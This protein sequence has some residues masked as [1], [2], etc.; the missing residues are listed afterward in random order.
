MTET[1]L[2]RPRGAD[3]DRPRDDRQPYRPARPE[4]GPGRALRQVAGVNETILD[5][6]PEERPRYTRLGAIVLN[7]GVMAMLSMA[8]LLSKV[9]VPFVAVVPI[10]VMWGYLILSFDGW[11]VASTHG[12][13]GLAKLRTY[14]PRMAISILMGVVIAEP[15]LLWVFGPAIETEVRDQREAVVATYEARLKE[16][17]PTS[18]AAPAAAGCGPFLLNVPESPESTRQELRNA[19]LERTTLEGRIGQIDKEIARREQL[20]RLECNGTKVDGTTGRPGVG[21]N[22]R[23]N[24]AEADRYQASSNVDKLRDDLS[25]LDRR[26]DALTAREGAASGTY[27]G[28]V[29]TE[30]SKRVAD[31]RDNQDMIGIL[32]EIK[33]LDS[34]AHKS[35]FVL[36]ASWLLRLLLV[37]ID[38]LPV[39]TKLMSRTTTYDVL[40]GRQLDVSGRLH[41]KYTTEREQRDGGRID[42]SIL[43]NEH[44]VRAQMEQIDE[45]DRDAR[46]QREAVL[47]D[48]IERLAARLRDD[49]R[50]GLG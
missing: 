33:A 11:L 20:A 44:R 5:W 3:D 37:A 9:D 7:T 42:V 32:D 46:A 35:G 39:L 17:N 30:I 29:N 28:A 24:R 18:G 45:A 16:C 2:L 34:L 43:E 10:A 13:L 25:A 36:A 12:V 47:D 6:V 1:L 40:L 41:E 26:I 49:P 4:Y 19:K 50:G 27:A 48:Q 15:L 14:L 22:C 21:P 31:K 38:C 8:V 23:R